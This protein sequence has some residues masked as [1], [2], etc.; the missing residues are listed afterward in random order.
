[1]K[2]LWLYIV[3][4]PFLVSEM[5]KK[6]YGETKPVPGIA[7]LK[8]TTAVQNTALA[9]SLFN[10]GAKHQGAGDFKQALT[11]FEKSLGIYQAIGNEKKVGDCFGNVAVTHYY[12]GDYSTALSFFEK[13]VAIYKKINYSKGVSSILNNMGGVYFYLGQYPKALDLY[14]QAV[15]TQKAIG[16]EKNLAATTQNIGSIYFREQDY[17]NA[18]KYYDESYFVYKKLKNEKGVAQILNGIGLVYTKQGKYKKAF[19]NLN[20]SLKI[21]DK[22]ENKQLKMEVLSSLGGLFYEQSDFEKAL[23]Y[24][25]L[26]LKFSEEIGS[27][28]YKSDSHIAIGKIMQKSG[29]DKEAVDKCRYGLEFAEKLGAVSLRREGCE[30]LYNAYKS[31]GKTRLALYYYEKANVFED[32]LKLEETS[33]RIMNMEFQ[34]QQ[35]VDSISYVQKE[36]VIQLRHKEEVAKRD[37]QRNIIIITLCF[38]LLIAAGLWNRLNYV[39]KSRTVLQVEKDRSEALLLNILPQEIAEELKEKGSVHARDYDLVSILFTDF[40]SFTQTAEK[41]SPQSL[42]EEISV[43][44]KAFDLITEKYQIEKI[45]T[46]GDAY[47]AAGGIP[48]PDVNAPKNI[49]LAGLEMQAFMMAR[50]IE[51]RKAHRPS[52]EMRLGIH[53]GPIVAGVVGVK[54]FQ[55]DVWG[56][57]VNTASRIESNGMVEKVNVSEALYQLL[58]G[59]ACFSFEYRGIINAKGKGDIAM[60]FVERNTS[61]QADARDRVAELMLAKCLSGDLEMAGKRTTLPDDVR[62]S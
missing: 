11:L 17:A 30:C 15:T 60:Y 8:N 39:R 2:K 23:T 52:F 14:K 6:M 33:N 18:M 41:M 42:V 28:Q 44:F 51:N 49:V 21:A 3:F 37:K 59:E 1:M 27:S 47:M 19:E 32:S 12:Q 31:L 57:T 5:E 61:T 13:S 36:S 48:N 40:K 20:Q 46:I 9:D 58:K 10:L 4:L 25:N 24:F 53:T 26:C 50:A 38:I 54:K 16:D 56:D 45:K 55:Y 62:T 22:E 35:L 29:K 34:K 7:T 43:C